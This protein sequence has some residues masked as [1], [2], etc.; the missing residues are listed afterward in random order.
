MRKLQRRKQLVNFY[1]LNIGVWTEIAEESEN[2][3]A[4]VPPDVFKRL[5]N[6]SI[7]NGD[8]FYDDDYVNC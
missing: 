3:V 2:R 7:V 4:T 6:Y 8:G 1:T 5:I